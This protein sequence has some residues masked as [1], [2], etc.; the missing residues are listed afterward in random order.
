VVVAQTADSLEHRYCSGFQTVHFRSLR[1]L[2]RF[3]LALTGKAKTTGSFPAAK[4]VPSLSVGKLLSHFA[5]AVAETLLALC[6]LA[7]QVCVRARLRTAAADLTFL[8]A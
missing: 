3:Q 2:L 1:L 7:S 6:T 5:T 8:V 4:H